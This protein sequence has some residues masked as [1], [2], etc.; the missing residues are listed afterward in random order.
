MKPF[1]GN[2]GEARSALTRAF[3]ISW[4]YKAALRS[5][6]KPTAL[7]FRHESDALSLRYRPAGHQG[8]RRDS[9]YKLVDIRNPGG[10]AQKIF[11]VCC[12]RNSA[13][14][15]NLFV[16][17]RN[18][19]ILTSVWHFNFILLHFLQ[20]VTPLPALTLQSVFSNAKRLSTYNSNGCTW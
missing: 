13:P 2:Q 11:W 14:S 10:L 20:C 5:W 16:P 9:V 12:N 17:G 18:Q 15:F 3:Q 7:A 1:R 4:E 6:I 8:Q 19:A